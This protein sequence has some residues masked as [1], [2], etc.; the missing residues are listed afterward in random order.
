MSA[1]IADGKTL[2]LEIQESLLERVSLLCSRGIEPQLAVVI[3]GDDPASHVYVRNKE[4]A[5]ERCGIKSMRIDL[6][7]TSTLDD[8]LNVVEGLNSDESVHGILVQSPAPEGVDELTIASTISP[9]KDVD[10]FHPT[11]LGKLV[12]GDNSGLLPC[13]PSGVMLMLEESNANLSGAKALVIGRSRIV[14]MPMALM[15]AQRGA[16]ATVTIAH[17]RT[18]DL[19]GLCREADVVVAAIGSPH[20]VKPEWIKPASFVVD[21]GISRL[22]GGTLAGDVDPRVADVAGWMTPVPGGV[23][24]M[25]IAMLMANTVRAAETQ[26]T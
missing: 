9:E 17:S 16:D 11:N 13:T 23:G 15:L 19:S 4:R 2:G 18:N 8:I 22:E 12:Q 25:T 1:I 10:V 3:A 14:G 6:P 24:P 21:V 5:C 20:I 26:S 7:P